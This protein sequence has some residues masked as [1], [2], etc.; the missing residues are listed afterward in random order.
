[1]TYNLFVLYV[2][3]RRDRVVQWS[4]DFVDFFNVIPITVE[5]THRMIR[6]ASEMIEYTRGLLAERRA[7]PRDD[8]HG[9]LANARNLTEDEIVANAMLLL[10][11]ECCGV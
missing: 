7:Y 9:T 8:L 10:L 4:V 3:K 1:M 11:D 2:Y 5:T 6:S